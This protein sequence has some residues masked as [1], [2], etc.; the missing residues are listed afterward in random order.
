VHAAFISPP[1]LQRR[2]DAVKTPR[3][4]ASVQEPAAELP[5][6]QPDTPTDPATP[7]GETLQLKL[8]NSHSHRAEW[9]SFMRLMANPKR[10]TPAMSEA[11]RPD[12]L[13]TRANLGRLP[14]VLRRS[15]HALSHGGGCMLA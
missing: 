7:P 6:P 15:S 4:A 1:A 10:V 2:A 5:T 9:Q 12:N 14:R 3:P 11:A 8:P 13:R